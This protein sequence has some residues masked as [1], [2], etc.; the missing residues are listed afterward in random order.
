MGSVSVRCLL[1]GNI[2]HKHYDQEYVNNACSG[3]L[4]TSFGGGWLLVEI[5]IYYIK[6]TFVHFIWWCMVIGRV[7]DILYKTHICTLYLVVYVD[8]YSL[9]YII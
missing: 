3:L 2:R 8:W 9:S 4:Y 7:C 1:C 6:L 5:E